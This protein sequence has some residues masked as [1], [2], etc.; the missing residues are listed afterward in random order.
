MYAAIQLA[1][2]V[3]A[4]LAALAMAGNWL[5]WIHALLTR[6]HFS[7]VPVIGGVLGAITFAVAPY[8]PEF[9]PYIS[10]FGRFWWVPLLADLGCLPM[11][12]TTAIYQIHRRFR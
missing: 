2:C 4:L 12:V 6:I 11:L 9:G 1:F 5:G 3:L 7:F 10:R 8:I